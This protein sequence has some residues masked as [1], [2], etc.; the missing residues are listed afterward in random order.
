MRK[1][2]VCL[3]A[4]CLIGLIPQF[5][6]CTSE[7]IFATL[8]NETPANFY[9]SPILT[10]TDKW[11]L[12]LTWSGTATISATVTQVVNG[13]ES[14]YNPNPSV[15]LS[16][17]SAGYLIAEVA[18]STIDGYLIAKLESTTFS[19]VFGQFFINGVLSKTQ[20]VIIYKALHVPI[21]QFTIANACRVK[22]VANGLSATPKIGVFSKPIAQDL[23]PDFK[24]LTG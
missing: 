17:G 3:L 16:G 21:N 15:T 24:S 19:T 4:I 22:I 20:T 9:K 11:K 5:T 10:S 13:V 2:Q 18:Q 6:E 12:V 8:T 14:P 23:S 1:I 7:T